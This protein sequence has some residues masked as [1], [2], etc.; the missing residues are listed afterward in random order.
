MRGLDRKKIMSGIAGA[1]ITL[2][3]VAVTQVA[4][5]QPAAAAACISQANLH[6]W[7]VTNTSANSKSP[8][9]TTTSNCQDVNFGLG[10][11]DSDTEPNGYPRG[12]VRVCFV[13]AGYCQS[14]WKNFNGA[15]SPSTIVVASNVSDGTTFKIEFDWGS[16]TDNGKSGFKIYA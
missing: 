16:D 14:S 11:W 8:T 4:A 1:A 7:Y 5:V 9:Y 13:G 12:K 15:T 10:S 3:A 6:A 2:S